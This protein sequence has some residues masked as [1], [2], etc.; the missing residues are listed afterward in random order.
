MIRRTIWLPFLCGMMLAYL[1]TG[2]MIGVSFS[3][4]M[5]ALNLLGATY[6]ALT[7]PVSMFCTS[8]GLDCSPMPPAGSALANAFFT[9][10]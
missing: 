2:L 8:A 6:S 5:P 7:W 10:D 3:R 9:F 1:L 4:A